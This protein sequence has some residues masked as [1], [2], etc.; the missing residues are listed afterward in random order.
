MRKLAASSTLLLLALSGAAT[1]AQSNAG[2]VT[3]ISIQ[4]SCAV[5]ASNLNFGNV[6]VITG[7]ET[8]SAA[9]DVNCSLGTPWTMSFNGSSS[10]T[11]FTGQMA[12]GANHVNY[13]AALSAAGGIGPGSFAIDGVIA[14]QAT[15]P[16]GLYTD[17]RTLYLNY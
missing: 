17:N 5:T 15:P 12:S 4:T 11:S 8:A 6:G 3:R 14:A 13:S 2:F 16:P 9:V 1:A 7:G 10:V